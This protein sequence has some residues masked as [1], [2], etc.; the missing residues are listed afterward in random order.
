[1]GVVDGAAVSL[2]V[3]AAADAVAATAIASAVMAAPKTAFVDV[4]T[5]VLID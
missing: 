1:M 3:V 5:F 4:I 2:V